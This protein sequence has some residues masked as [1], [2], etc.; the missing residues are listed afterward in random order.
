MSTDDPTYYAEPP[1]GQVRISVNPP[2][3]RD[4]LMAAG[5][6][7]TTIAA[8]ALALR[9]YTRLRVV[10]KGL[11]VDDCEGTKK[12]PNGVNLGYLLDESRCFGWLTD[13]VVLCKRACFGGFRHVACD[14]GF[15]EERCVESRN[16]SK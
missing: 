13:M 9:L 10:E 5:I 1:P 11:K 16:S 14:A 7:T 15:R 6:A 3:R 12:N 2:T 8:V 4:D